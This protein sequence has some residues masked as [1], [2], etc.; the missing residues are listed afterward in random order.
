MTAMTRT[1]KAGEIQRTIIISFALAGRCEVWVSETQ[2]HKTTEETY[3]LA[4]QPS[5]FGA[6]FTVRKCSDERE[7]YDVLLSRNGHPVLARGERTSR[8]SKHVGTL[9]CACKR[10]AKRS[11]NRRRQRRGKPGEWFTRQ[12]KWGGACL[13]HVPTACVTF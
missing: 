9:K 6:A 11:C 2:G 3:L 13:I 8:T 1:T 5:D 10:S 7:V 12:R 4:R